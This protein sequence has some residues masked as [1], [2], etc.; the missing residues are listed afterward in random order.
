MNINN[1][2]YFDV[3]GVSH[4]STSDEIRRARNRLAFRFHP[5][6]NDSDREKENVM[7]LL[8][9]AVET[10]TDPIKRDR[11]LNNIND[12]SNTTS[13]SKEFKNKQPSYNLRKLM[14]Y[15]VTN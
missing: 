6:R 2:D 10:L 1:T 4:S 15:S 9:I 14:C 5:D 3:L 13:D 7:K 12:E 8:N 11:Y